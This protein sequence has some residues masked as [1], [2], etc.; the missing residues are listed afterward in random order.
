[1]SKRKEENKRDSRRGS[2]HFCGK[3]FERARLQNVDEILAQFKDGAENVEDENFV[4]SLAWALVEHRCDMLD[5][6]GRKIGD[7]F[8]VSFTY[9]FSVFV[10]SS[11]DKFCFID[12]LVFFG[13]E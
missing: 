1:M 4:I 12:F 3:C 2:A 5:E 7:Y 8:I 9:H 6:R 10:S 11:W 13:V